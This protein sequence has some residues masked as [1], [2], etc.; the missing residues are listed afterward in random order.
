MW[1][2]P[3]FLMCW[4]RWN[5]L[6]RCERFNSKRDS[7]ERRQAGRSIGRRLQ[8]GLCPPDMAI[9]DRLTNYWPRCA[10]CRRRRRSRY[11]V[12]HPGRWAAASDWRHRRVAPLWAGLIV[13]LNQKLNRR[14]RFVNLAY[15][16]SMSRQA[17]RDITSGNNGVYS[18]G[19]G[20]DPVTGLGSPGAQLLQARQHVASSQFNCDEATSPCRACN[21]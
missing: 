8:R 16:R 18:A 5:N 1:T 2:S 7:V 4:H 19:P 12:Q 21:N 15:T 20:W 13:L 9:C 6:D 3:H 10:R 14:L 11:R 17:F